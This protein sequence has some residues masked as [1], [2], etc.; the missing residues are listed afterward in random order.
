MSVTA[1]APKADAAAPAE[2]PKKKGKLKLILVVV[3]LLALGGGAV[4][5]FMFKPEGKPPPPEAGIVVKLEPIQ[6]NLAGEHY[7]RIGIAL[8]L[9]KGVK[10]ADGSKALDATIDEFSGAKIAEVSEPQQ[11]RAMKK[12]L[13]EK[14]KHLYE[15]EVMGVYYTDFVTQ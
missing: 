4:Y 2:E 14:L 10:E 11:R 12:E 6:V 13:V 3:L 1:V 8:Q 15:G 5:W 7:L 9:V